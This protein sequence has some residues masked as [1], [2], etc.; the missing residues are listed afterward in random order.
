M[1]ACSKCRRT[2]R[3]VYRAALGPGVRSGARAMSKPK[4]IPQA[5]LKGEH[6]SK[7]DHLSNWTKLKADELWPAHPFSNVFPEMTEAVFED[8]KQ[9]IKKNGQVEPV[10]LYERAIL[11]GR[12][13]ARAL[14]ELGRDIVTREFI[15]TEGE[16]RAFVI[17]LNL[18][19]R[20]LDES[21]R[22][23]IAGRLAN[24]Q[25]GGDR[26]SDQ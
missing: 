8:F 17:S 11:D 19:R 20:H 25:N 3:S 15:G 6:T 10:I 9:D 22:A 26:K 18:Q 16:A 23:M 24:I 2:H 14:V 5:F 1:R 4:K 7:T 12:H 21:Q 13:R